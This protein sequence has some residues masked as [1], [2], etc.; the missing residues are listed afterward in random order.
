MIYDSDDDDGNWMYDGDYSK[1]APQTRL[2]LQWGLM[3]M[4]YILLIRNDDDNNGNDD[5]GLMM[6]MMM[7]YGGDDDGDWI[8]DGDEDDDCETCKDDDSGISL[9]LWWRPLD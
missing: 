4:I 6:M 7:L 1:R 5:W 2:T 8:H 3:M 9:D